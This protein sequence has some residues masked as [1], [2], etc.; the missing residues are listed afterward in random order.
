MLMY[1]NLCSDQLLLYSD[2]LT[3]NDGMPNMVV[4]PPKNTSAPSVSGGTLWA[5]TINNVFYTFGG[6][7]W[8]TDVPPFSTWM[9]NDSNQVWSEIYTRG[10]TM[11]YVA[12]GMGTAAPDSG[13][14]Y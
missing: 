6:L 11:S 13:M 9:Y 5:D 14:G 1:R 12:F 10:D 4:A 3:S 2:L 7:F 8:Q